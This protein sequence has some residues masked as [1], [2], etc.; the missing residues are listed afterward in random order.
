MDPAAVELL[1]SPRGSSLLAALPPYEE[2]QALAL[3]QR[4]RDDGVEPALAAAALTQ[5]RLRARAA[6][7]LGA[8]AASMLFTRAGLEQATRAPV[9]ALHAERYVSAG[10]RHVA[11][12]TAG[13]GTDALAL[14][15]AGLRVT[16]C[17]IDEATALV[18]GHNL[19]GHPAA[20]VVHGDGLALDLT[21]RGID[22]VYADPARRTGSGTRIF[23]PHA[24]LPPL[25]AVWALREEV[26]AVGIKIGPGVPHQGL[27]D[28]A[29]AEWVSVD[30]DVVEAGLWFGPLAPEGPG[31][32][33]TVLRH[34][35]DGLRRAR[36]H[37]AAGTAA[38]PA[39]V[40][41]GPGSLGGYLFEPDGAVIRAGLVGPLALEHGA[42][43]LDP[44]IAYLTGDGPV[45]A[46]DGVPVASAYRVLDVMPFHLKRLKAYLRERKVGTLTIKKRGTA[47]VPEELRSRL[48]L[49]G[50]ASATVVL[51]R[52][53]G[54]QQ[55]ILVDP[56]VDPGVDQVL[57]PPRTSSPSIPSPQEAR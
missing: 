14:A 23:D 28:D 33:A 35:P 43:L 34:G 54:S 12:L 27:P 37:A 47:V 15:A 57:D 7:K 25:D 8:R 32:G 50:P 5:S 9:A 21:A 24:Y 46:V 29:E 30:G 10:L 2:S 36:L 42:R 22:G 51:T 45:P 16:A 17:E 49:R 48:A 52:I 40:V 3:S 26:P 13:I 4:L 55:V 31:R 41:A 56:V 19:A 1:L 38:P 44:T 18:A 20:E 6:T 11:D 53:A 39:A